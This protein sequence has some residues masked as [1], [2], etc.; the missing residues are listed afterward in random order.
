MAGVMEVIHS[1][2]FD[3]CIQSEGS[4][5]V[6]NRPSLFA[7]YQ[8]DN[9]PGSPGTSRPS[10]PMEVILVVARRIEVDDRCHRVDVNSSGGNIGGDECLRSAR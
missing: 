1:R 5:H 4:L 7:G 3:A 8:A 9:C 6:L 10:R 2:L